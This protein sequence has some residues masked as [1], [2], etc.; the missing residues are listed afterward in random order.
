LDNDPGRVELLRKMGFK[1]YFGDASRR[2]LLQ[3]AG[4]ER[5]KLIIIALEPAEKRLE[6]ID[7]IKKHFPNLRM[8][9]RSTNRYDAYDQMNAGMLHVY[10][11][12]IDTA[13]RVGVDTMR[14]LGYRS[15]SAQR[16]ARA[17]FKLDE[18][19]LKKLASIQDKEEYILSARFHIEEM[20]RM[21]QQDIMVANSVD[22]GWDEESLIADANKN[23]AMSS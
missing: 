13:L 1:V 2:D 22:N 8:L 7:T 11:E 3:A 16:A 6:M 14:F 23:V 21:L 4:A 15:Y 18:A 17:F 9:V 20:E 5:A 10:R 12:T 19:N